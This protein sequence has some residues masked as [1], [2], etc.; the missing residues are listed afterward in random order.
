MSGEEENPGDAGQIK[1][2]AQLEKLVYHAQ[3]VS[4][5]IRDGDYIAAAF[6]MDNF[7]DSYNKSAFYAGLA[8]SLAGELDKAEPMK[9]GTQSH[10][11][12]VL[13]QLLEYCRSNCD[14]F[15]AQPAGE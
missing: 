12:E 9:D 15:S 4:K 2:E 11:A 7:P 1:D 3:A 13:K 10:Q 6:V 14:Y 5:H 8:I